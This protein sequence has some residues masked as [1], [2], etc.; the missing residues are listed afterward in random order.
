MKQIRTITIGLGL[1]L[2]IATAA[3]QDSTAVDSSAAGWAERMFRQDLQPQLLPEFADG[4]GVVFR[5]LNRDGFADIYIVCFRNLNRLFINQGKP[6]FFLDYTIQSGLGGNLMSYGENNLELGAS[7]VDYNNDGWQD[8]L[9]VGWGLTTYLYPQQANLSFRENFPLA[10]IYYPIDGNAGIWADVNRDGEL[11]LFVTDEH[12]HNRLFMNNGAGHFRERSKK[13][14]L[15]QPAISQGAAFADVDQD[16]YPDLY[17]CNWFAPDRFYRNIEGKQYQQMALPLPHL[18]DS[19]KSN[20]ASFGDIDNDGDLDLLVTDR[21]GQTRLYENN[22]SPERPEAWSFRDITDTAG[23]ANDLPAYGGIIADLNND[24]WQ[25]IFFTNI[26]PNQLYLNRGDRR[27]QLIYQETFS[28]TFPR[29]GYSTGAAVADYDND[30]DLDLFVANKDT[31]SV[32]YHNPLQAGSFLRLVLEGVTSNRDAIGSK[33]WLYQETAPGDFS[34]LYGFREISG[35]TGYLSISEAAAHFGVETGK[36]Y[37][38]R[39]RFPSGTEIRTAPLA[40]G[41]IYPVAESGGMQK[42]VTR[43]F[44]YAARVGRS[45]DFWLNTLLL[46]TWLLLLIGFMRFS[47][48]RYL[49]QNNQTTLFLISTMVLGYLIFLLLSG[50]PTWIVLLAQIGT[51]LT[52]MAVLA[53]FMEKLHRIETQRYGYRQLLQ[54]FSQQLIFIKNN[55]ELYERLVSTIQQ[56]MK[57][58]F[59]SALEVESQVARFKTVAGIWRHPALQLPLSP[60]L[61]GQLITAPAL[62]VA[63]LREDLPAL[64]EVEARLII[65]LARKEKLLAL[66]LLGAREDGGELR[67]E[68]LGILQILAGQAAIAIENNI[69]IEETRT[70]TQRLT[71]AEIR[72]QYVTELETQHQKLE[73]LYRELQETQTQLI[74]SEKL[75][76]LG[77]LVAGIAHELNNPISFVYANMRELQ[78]YNAAISELLDLLDQH[79]GAAQFQ[80]RLREKLRELD[81][82]YDLHFIQK[83]IDN[84][85]NE[86]LEGSE[87]VKTVVQ[88][89]RNFSRLDEAAFK[90]VDLHEG[91]ESTLLLLNN[92][93]K[94]RITVHR[95]YGKLP[96]VPCNPGHLN[97]V[98]MN[99]LLNAIQA[100][101]G[102]GDIWITT[103]VEGEQA[104]IGIR[105]SGRGIPAEVQHRIF[106]PFFTTKPVGKGTG[107]GLSISY[108]IIQKHGGQITFSSKAGEGTEFLI[109]LPLTTNFAT[110]AQRSQR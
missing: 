61:Q 41:G 36:R 78:Q 65:P 46:L 75:A 94:N 109:R 13:F 98:F 105:D 50:Q 102:K 18:Q 79:N 62:R 106:D 55:S 40:P 42:S 104:V 35:G 10:E 19:L 103:T 107:L 54:N 12:Y 33:I 24:G 76:G 49:W 9:I 71:E 85:I 92:E 45:E 59:C 87:R 97:Q 6:D 51:L 53:G 20:G 88:N 22:F 26:G 5:D 28:P 67:S 44:Q 101:D 7:A 48:R 14:G 68:D 96:A 29:R 47:I 38:A 66:L 80:D 34:R 32:L 37:Q 3:G 25:D 64:H 15:N 83:D 70:L 100:I 77:Q 43:A 90:A 57:V 84:L 63:A 8:I 21:D 31:L 4:Y 81:Q 110:E 60:A 1:L 27:F 17:V 16:G 56:S 89:L 52:L 86:S 91:L 93:L 39:I 30:G 108:N 73:Q 69:Y 23:I 95:N 74:Q 2:C 11:D 82:K 72:E 99:L 58:T